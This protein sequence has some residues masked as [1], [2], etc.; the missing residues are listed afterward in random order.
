MLSGKC[1]LNQQWDSIKHIL[2]WPNSVTLTTPNDDSDVE[3]EE[4]S[5]LPV[6]MQHDTVALEGSF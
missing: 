5:L 6:G 4:L 1:K 2:E 3:Q